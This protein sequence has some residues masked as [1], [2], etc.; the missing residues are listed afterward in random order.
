MTDTTVCY[1]IDVTESEIVQA[2][3]D[4][5][6]TLKDIQRMTK[7]CTGSQCK[8]K[9]PKGQCCSADILALIKR[10][11]GTAPAAKHCRCE[12]GAGKSRQDGSE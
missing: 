2:I 10:E 9:N 8:E 6:R 1:C 5:A 11:T 12:S 3:R 7:A 4:G